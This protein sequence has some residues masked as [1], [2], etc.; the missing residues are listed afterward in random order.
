MVGVPSDYLVST[1]LQLWLFELLVLVGVMLLLLLILLLLLLLM[2]TENGGKSVKK[3]VVL[4]CVVVVIVA[5]V[6]FVVV[7]FIK[8]RILI[9]KYNSFIHSFKNK[10]K[11][12]GRIAQG[13]KA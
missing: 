5:G 4:I 3:E 9:Q 13:F 10:F 12:R 1:Q 2:L 8:S 7:F 6:V 11:K